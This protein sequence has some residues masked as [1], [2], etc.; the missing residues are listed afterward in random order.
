MTCILPIEITGHTSIPCVSPVTDSLTCPICQSAYIFVLPLCL[1]SVQREATRYEPIPELSCW[2]LLF[3]C[4]VLTAALAA[5]FVLINS[6]VFA[7]GLPQEMQV[8]VF[9]HGLLLLLLRGLGLK[10]SRLTLLIL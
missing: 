1:Q 10:G 5:L 4:P 8:L 3:V 9:F 2:E 7:K 6:T